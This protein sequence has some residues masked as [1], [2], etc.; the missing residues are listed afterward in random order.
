MKFDEKFFMCRNNPKG[1][2]IVNKLNFQMLKQNANKL[3][4]VNKVNLIL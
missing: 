4:V 2:P 3:L 1:K